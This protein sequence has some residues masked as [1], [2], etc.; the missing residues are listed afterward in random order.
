MLLRRLNGN[1]LGVS[2]AGNVSIINTGSPEAVW[3]SSTENYLTINTDASCRSDI[4]ATG[5]GGVVRNSVGDVVCYVYKV[6]VF[7]P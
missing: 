3:S 2:L 7:F 4:D 1:L 5:L 6:S